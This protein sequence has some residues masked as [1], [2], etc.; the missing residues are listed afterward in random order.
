MVMISAKRRTLGT[1]M[2]EKVFCWGRLVYLA[3]RLILSLLFVFIGESIFLPRPNSA[4]PSYLRRI[5]IIHIFEGMPSDQKV[6]QRKLSLISKSY[7]SMT[8]NYRGPNQG[9]NSSKI[10]TKS[11]NRPRG[12]RVLVQKIFKQILQF[13]SSGTCHMEQLTKTLKSTNKILSWLGQYTRKF[14]QKT[15]SVMSNS[16]P[17]G[18]I[19]VSFCRAGKMAV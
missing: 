16:Y 3:C 19:W 14:A 9:N 15:R 8:S 4:F 10:W 7:F 13:S 18:C 6:T 17:S 5:R 1:K 12:K 2:K 11:A